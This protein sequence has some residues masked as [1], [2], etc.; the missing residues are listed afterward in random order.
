MFGKCFNQ[1]LLRSSDW[2]LAHNPAPLLALRLSVLV[3]E[4][5]DTDACLVSAHPLMSGNV[6]CLSISDGRGMVSGWVPGKCKLH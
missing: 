4:C 2:P 3:L 6:A 1:D 5:N